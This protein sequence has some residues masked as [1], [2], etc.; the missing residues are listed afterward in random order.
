MLLVSTVNMKLQKK[1][2]KRLKEVL[3]CGNKNTITYGNKLIKW[4]NTLV[5]H[6]LSTVSQDLY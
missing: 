5:N 6:E 2:K 1:K 4:K 3:C